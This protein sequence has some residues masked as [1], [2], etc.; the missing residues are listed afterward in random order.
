[1]DIA[2]IQKIQELASEESRLKWKNYKKREADDSFKNYSNVLC[3]FQTH[4]KSH[5]IK[6]VLS[7]FLNA[8]M[9]NIILFADGCFDDTVQQAQPFLTGRKHSIIVL[10]DLHEIHNYRFAVS[11]AWASSAEFG[12]FLQDDDLYPEDFRWLDYGIEMMRKDPKLCVIG[13]RDGINFRQISPASDTF[14]TDVFYIQGNRMGLP[15]SSEVSLVDAQKPLAGFNFQY[16]Q[17]VNRAPHLIRI[18]E[19]LK[20]T[21]FD[22]QFEPFQDDDTN[23]CL[24]LWKQGLRVG[25][26][27]GAK[28][29]RDIGIG[30]MRLSGHLTTSRRPA[31]TKRNH[32][33]LFERYSNF[34]NSGEL[35][36]QVD[37]ANK[38]IVR[39]FL[40][41]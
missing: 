10:N 39:K 18:G 4:N 27:S 14:E 12:L 5:L 31:H 35:A 29:A 36:Q 13:Y 21:N 38:E 11:S 34:I 40:Y 6:E 24:Q 20:H 25:L 15:G 33:I 17:T 23:Y 32:N 2:S 28:I 26:V 1:M 9:Q 7:P 30:G 37:N 41:L 16:C 22:E 8:K 3:I 19:F